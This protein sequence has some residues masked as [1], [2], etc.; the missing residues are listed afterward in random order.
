MK[1]TG[2]AHKKAP[3]PDGVGARESPGVLIV[4]YVFL[5]DVRFVLVIVVR[6]DDA[7]DKGIVVC[8]AELFVNDL[9]TILRIQIPC[10][11]ITK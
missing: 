2:R 4:Y 5:N 10:W 3:R 1:S 7:D 6:I 9:L 11:F 8:V